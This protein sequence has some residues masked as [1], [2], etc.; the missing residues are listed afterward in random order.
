VNLAS[1]TRILGNSH[2]RPNG[3]QVLG[4]NSFEYMGETKSSDKIRLTF[5]LSNERKVF[6]EGDEAKPYSISREF[7]FSMHTKSKLRKA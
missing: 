1:G 6:K 7:G 2:L 3:R 5:E 4:T